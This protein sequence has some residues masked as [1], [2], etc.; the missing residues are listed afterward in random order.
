MRPLSIK[1]IIHRELQ[2]VIGGVDSTTSQ[3]SNEKVAIQ[4]I[5]AELTQL[6]EK[7]EGTEFKQ[8]L[9]HGFLKT[10]AS[11]PEEKRR[12]IFLNIAEG[13]CVYHK[14]PNSVKNEKFFEKELLD[15]LKDD[16]KDK[17][18]KEIVNQLKNLEADTL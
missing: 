6:A 5:T 1:K 8:T 10:L 9:L 17:I 2:V 18:Y 4:T 12:E 13:L 15:G 16:I 14:Y 3:S 11:A 7:Y